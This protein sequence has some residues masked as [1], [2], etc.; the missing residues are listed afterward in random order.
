[1]SAIVSDCLRVIFPKLNPESGLLAHAAAAATR[2]FCC[3]DALPLPWLHLRR[4][5]TQTANGKK[6]A[7][8]TQGIPWT[9][10]KESS[11]TDG[12][13]YKTIL[14]PMCM[15]TDSED[16]SGRWQP[17]DSLVTFSLVT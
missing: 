16:P 7:D 15:Q 4:E 6:S 10:F 9:F 8:A 3:H 11:N 5:G 12:R 14:D 13:T 1:M 17:L 2:L